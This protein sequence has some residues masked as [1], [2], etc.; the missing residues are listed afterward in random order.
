[1]SLHPTSKSIF[2]LF[3]FALTIGVAAIFGVGQCPG[4]YLR[5][6]STQQIPYS[7]VY[8]DKTADMTGD[9]K[10]DLI[11]SQDVSG[12]DTTRERI[13]IIPG[14]GNGTFGT[15][16]TIDAPAPN[17]F[18]DKYLVGKVNNDSLN[19]IVLFYKYDTNP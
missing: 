1:M 6:T 15:A 3:S 8:F 12:S 11:A 2:S 19:D 13:L 7:R 14:N 5:H 17:A 10:P 4:V 9:G 16:I 18:D